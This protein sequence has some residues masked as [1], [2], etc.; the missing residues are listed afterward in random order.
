[1]VRAKFH[2]TSVQPDEYGTNI[3]LEAVHEGP[4][5]ES[6]S[7]WTPGGSI[8]MYITNPDAVADLPLG[9]VMYVDFTP[10]EG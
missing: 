10:A 2:V 5:N 4:G 7:K 8:E 3:R 1:M 9:A 6:W